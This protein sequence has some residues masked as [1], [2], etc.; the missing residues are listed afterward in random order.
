M[1]ASRSSR[2][3]KKADKVLN[4]SIGIVSLLILVIGG[5]ILVSLLNSPNDQTAAT[6][7][8]SQENKSQTSANQK[9]SNDKSSE[10][11]SGDKA[12]TSDQSDSQTTTD[13]SAD[14]TKDD[15]QGSD[16]KAKKEAKDKKAT[17]EADKEKSGSASDSE[18]R[19]SYDEGSADWNAQLAALSSATG[20]PEDQMT[21]YWLGNGGGPNSS[22]GRVASKDTPGKKFVVH[23]VYKDGKW[24]ADDVKE[25]S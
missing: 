18:H 12:T 4:W 10:K 25:P 19:A 2:N 7:N 6:N 8:K 3:R 17:E 1:G 16:D 24:Q 5:I 14:S 11:S 15:S 9:S 22:L 20:I 13:G 23:L 21:L